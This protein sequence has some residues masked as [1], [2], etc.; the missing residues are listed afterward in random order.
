MQC[1]SSSAT[2]LSDAGGGSANRRG[3][4]SCRNKRN[5]S[6]RPGATSTVQLRDA[7]ETVRL[8]TSPVM[9]EDGEALVAAR[10]KVSAKPG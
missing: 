2:T 9:D 10:P 3:Q 8:A 4:C 1:S 5:P 6:C 7:I